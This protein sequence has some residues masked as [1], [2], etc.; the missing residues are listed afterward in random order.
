MVWL[1]L[2][3]LVVPAAHAGELRGVVGIRPGP[4]GNAAPLVDA[5]VM[6]DGPTVRAAPDAPHAVV[7]QREHA[8]HPRVL[9]VPAGTTVDF[10]NA[11]P[12]LH[13]VN[14]ASPAKAFDVGLFDRGQTRSETFDVPGVIDLRCT[15]HPRMRGIV[16]VHANPYVAVTDAQGRYTMRDVP[17]GTHDVHFWGEDFVARRVAVS[18]PERGVAQ[19]DVQL[20]RAR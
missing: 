16:V 18:V 7:T 14:S 12:V 8:F 19:L 4:G 1:L 3:L 15:V 6:M 13:D 20:E 9:A 11:D 10:A 2:V 5:V 17:P